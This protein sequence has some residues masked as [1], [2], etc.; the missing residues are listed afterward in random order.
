MFMF[1]LANLSLDVKY[2][3]KIFIYIYNVLNTLY[4]IRHWLGW[5]FFSGIN[6]VGTEYE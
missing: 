3:F 4:L 1:P 2:L 5:A 6:S